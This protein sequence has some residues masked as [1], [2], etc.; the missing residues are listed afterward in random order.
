MGGNDDPKASSPQYSSP[1]PPSPSP[2]LD[3][4]DSSTEAADS[5]RSFPEVDSVGGISTTDEKRADDT[6][7]APWI[8]NKL[9]FYV[10]FPP[11][12]SHFPLSI[13]FFA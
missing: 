4:V 8:A 3:R 12:S 6:A 5:G 13:I 2:G 9:I 1:P 7:S 11:G 10:L